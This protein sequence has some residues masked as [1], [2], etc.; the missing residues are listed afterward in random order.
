[1]ASLHGRLRGSFG[2]AAVGSR[3]VAG[4]H[5]LGPD[6]Q[7]DHGLG[8]GE[9]RVGFGH[10]GGGEVGGAHA[11]ER[12]G[13]GLHALGAEALDGLTRG[14][15]PLFGAREGQRALAHLVAQAHHALG[16]DVHD[17]LVAEGAELAVEREAHGALG[18]DHHVLAR[19]ADHGVAAAGGA[20]DQVGHLG[21]AGAHGH[22]QALLVVHLEARVVGRVAGHDLA[23][24][25]LVE[26]LDGGAHHVLVGLGLDG[27]GDA[28]GLALTRERDGRRVGARDGERGDGAAVE[29][30]QRGRFGGFARASVRGGAAIGH[31]GHEG[32]QGDE[33]AA[34][35]EELLV[36]HRPVSLRA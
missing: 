16:R 2:H 14:E 30:R 4:L 29:V 31:E 6:G 32:N 26:L 1:M 8:G 35:D 24:L 19:H 15:R 3:R 12:G 7:R 18:G 25:E 13:H 5:G 17:A 21:V 23:R 28:P 33:D 27:R 34:R 11:R 20:E 36:L 9:P 10:L 22:A